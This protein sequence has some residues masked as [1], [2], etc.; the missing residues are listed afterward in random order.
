[1]RG[2][3]DKI[4]KKRRRGVETGDGRKACGAAPL[5]RR[6]GGQKCHKNV[7]PDYFQTQQARTTLAS[8]TTTGTMTV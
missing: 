2:R 7:L 8:A 3:E 1:M 5:Q 6:L 4:K